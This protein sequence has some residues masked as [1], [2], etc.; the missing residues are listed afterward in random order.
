MPDCDTETA[1]PALKAVESTEGA[2]GREV[3]TTTRSETFKT[4]S[5]WL[6][7]KIADLAVLGAT[8]LVVV[9][10]AVWPGTPFN[11]Q[12]EGACLVVCALF[13][14]CC[15]LGG[16]IVLRYASARRLAPLAYSAMSIVGVI[17]VVAVLS[18]FR[19]YGDIGLHF[20]YRHPGATGS[21][22]TITAS[23]DR[24]DG[25]VDV[26][27]VTHEY[28]VLTFK[29]VNGDGKKEL[30]FRKHEGP[31]EAIVEVLVDKRKNAPRFRLL[32]GKIDLDRADMFDLQGASLRGGRF[33]E[34]T[35]TGEQL[36]EAACDGGDMS[37]CGNLA[38]WYERGWGATD[39]YGKAVRLYR[40]GCEGGDR[41]SCHM[42]GVMYFRA[43]DKTSAARFFRK[44]CHF[45]SNPNDC[46]LAKEME[47][48]PTVRSSAAVEGG[49]R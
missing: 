37:A 48:K 33:L 7:L 10:I 21:T 1:G 17:A 35:N 47:K 45:W 9:L 42:L 16:D 34:I 46:N 13:V 26:F 39:E 44:A 19:P 28:L 4:L 6:V 12:D 49:R 3:E 20:N 31:D 32:Y 18:Y 14:Y 15:V 29:D 2:A 41:W 25:A 38:F 36:Y 24:R 43:T 11:E 5:V 40:R 22:N 30:V 23:L 27:S 8:A